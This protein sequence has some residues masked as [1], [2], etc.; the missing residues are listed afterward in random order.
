MYRDVHLSVPIGNLAM[1]FDIV[2]VSFY[3]FDC[4]D[5]HGI[6]Y[7]ERLYNK[8]CRWVTLPIITQVLHLTMLMRLFHQISNNCTSLITL[9]SAWY[10]EIF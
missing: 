9:Q 6:S 8:I 4:G 2:I 10:L 1:E 5:G 3:L 7:K